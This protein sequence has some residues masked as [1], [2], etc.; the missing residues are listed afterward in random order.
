[1]HKT[2]R[3][4]VTL[5]IDVDVD[6][7]ASNYGTVSAADIREDATDRAV[8]ALGESYDRSG[9]PTTARRVNVARQ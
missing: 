9:L 8:M 4:R 3:V 1:M 5:V 7:Y 6:E 2:L